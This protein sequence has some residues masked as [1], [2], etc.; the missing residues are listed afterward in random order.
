MSCQALATIDRGGLSADGLGPWGYSPAQVRHAYGLDQ[1][2]ANGTGQTIAII[3]AYDAPTIVNDLAVFKKQF[4]IAG[5]NLTKVNQSG[6]TSYP[7][8]NP[9]WAF[10]TSIDVEW[11]CAMAPVRRS[12][13]SKRMIIGRPIFSLRWITPLDMLR[14]S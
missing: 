14:S 9:A 12:S 8:A 3:T 10:E 5:C 13:W 2:R 1:V 11:V 6:G 4:G 7:G